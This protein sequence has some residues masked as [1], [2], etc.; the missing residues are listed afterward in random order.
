MPKYTVVQSYLGECC[1]NSHLFI[2]I[3]E[4]RTPHDAMRLA[5]TRRDKE[6]EDEDGNTDKTIDFG[7]SVVI[8]ENGTTTIFD[9]EGKDIT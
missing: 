3:T 6:T 7:D 5:R 9:P 1:Q 8:S 4:V 2:D